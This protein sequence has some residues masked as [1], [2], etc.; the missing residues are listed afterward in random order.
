MYLF[1]H[2]SIHLFTGVFLLFIYSFIY[3]CVCFSIYLFIHLFMAAIGGAHDHGYKSMDVE[4]AWE[5]SGFFGTNP[6][7]DDGGDLHA[8]PRGSSCPLDHGRGPDSKGIRHRILIRFDSWEP[9]SNEMLP[10]SLRKAWHLL[11]L[12]GTCR[13]LSN[14]G[15]ASISEGTGGTGCSSKHVNEIQQLL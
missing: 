13:S 7:A 12:K 1:I 4:L 6:V 2:L 15:R 11:P 10:K 5:S 9:V 3:P 8:T 14:T